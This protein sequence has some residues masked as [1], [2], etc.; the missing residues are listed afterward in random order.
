MED[1][2]LIL[3]SLSVAFAIAAVVLFLL[4]RKLAQKNKENEQTVSKYRQ[5]YDAVINVDEEAERRRL[6][7]KQEMEGLESDKDQASEEL[8]QLKGKYIKAKELYD[9]MHHEMSIYEEVKDLRE[10]GIYEPHFDF[11]TSEKCKEQILK[12]RELQKLQV[13]DGWA[14]VCDTVWT[15]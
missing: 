8:A 12:N 10:F 7:Y 5:D 4:Y 9:A 2:T 13:K 6:L 3:T 1:I 14:V 11:D 15:V